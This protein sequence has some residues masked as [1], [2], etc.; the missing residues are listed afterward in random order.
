VRHGSANRRG[1]LPRR[2]ALLLAL[3]AGVAVVAALLMRPSHGL[4][5][6]AQ[7]DARAH[8]IVVRLAEDV[9]RGRTRGLSRVVGGETWRLAYAVQEDRVCWV[10]LVPRT[11]KEGTCGTR[12]EISQRPLL[13]YMGARADRRDPSRWDGY[14]VYGLVSP[15]VR[16]IRVTL[17]DCSTLRVPLGTRPLYWVFVPARKLARGV[18]PNGFVA[19]V[20]GRRVRGTLPPLGDR[21]PS[22]QCASVR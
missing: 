20:G 3:V 16:S 21:L 13:V 19:E 2:F 17:S 11:S 9:Q 6:D 18:L 12:S 8:T 10:L 22:G 4:S 1:F 7:P 15:A 5:A 14:A